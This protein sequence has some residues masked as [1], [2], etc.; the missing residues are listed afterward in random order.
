MTTSL[1]GLPN[2]CLNIFNVNNLK[3]TFE[4][5]T[6]LFLM[7]NLIAL[8]KRSAFTSKGLHQWKQ[9]LLCHFLLAIKLF[10]HLSGKQS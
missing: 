1:V 6:F 10:S 9:Q 7:D 8:K 3:D 2:L 4:N 5:V